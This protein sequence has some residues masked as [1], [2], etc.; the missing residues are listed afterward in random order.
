MAMSHST[1]NWHW[2]TKYVGGWAKEWFTT[3]LAAASKTEGN[4]T[5]KVERVTEVEGDVE[6][7]RRKSKYAL[8]P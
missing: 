7:G 3:E 1:A 4:D 5:V 6:L 8:S 2:K